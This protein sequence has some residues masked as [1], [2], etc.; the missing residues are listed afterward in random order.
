MEA[1]GLA[2]DHGAVQPQA[3]IA[4]GPV[5]R[6]FAGQFRDRKTGLPSQ[7]LILA[8]GLDLRI[9][10]HGKGNV[11][12]GDVAVARVAGTVLAPGTAVGDEEHEHAQGH[13]DLGRRQAGPA[14]VPHGFQHVGGEPPDPRRGRIGDRVGASQQDGV[15]H[16]GDLQESHAGNMVGSGR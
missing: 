11:R 10:Q 2:L 6:H 5:A 9:D 8:Q 7:D 15:A 4:D 13:V 16:A 14:G 1:L 12:R 3:A